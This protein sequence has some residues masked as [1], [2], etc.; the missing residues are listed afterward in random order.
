LPEDD[1]RRRNPQFK[2][3]K[4]TQ[5]LSLV[6]RLRTIGE[7]YGRSPGEIAI[8][9]TLR[10]PA[11]TGAIVGVRRPSQVDGIIGAAGLDLTQDEIDLIG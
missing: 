4:L 10:H 5:N 8:A 2:E 3:P 1:W 7:R 6:D 9:W 11:V